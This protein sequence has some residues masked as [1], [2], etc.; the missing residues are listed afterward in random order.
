[1]NIVFIVIVDISFL[2]DDHI[3][4]PPWIWLN[5]EPIMVNTY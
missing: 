1:M 5:I 2:L 3:A 4:P